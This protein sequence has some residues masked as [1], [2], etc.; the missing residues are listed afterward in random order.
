MFK[1]LIGVLALLVLLV[2][3]PLAVIA[4]SAVITAADGVHGR[5]TQSRQLQ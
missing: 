5:T 3:M 2:M 1:V 4:F